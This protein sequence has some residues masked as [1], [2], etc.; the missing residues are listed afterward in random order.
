MKPISTLV[1]SVVCLYVL[2]AKFCPKSS[3]YEILFSPKKSFDQ[4]E[5]SIVLASSVSVAYFNLASTV[6]SPQGACP[7]SPE[8]CPLSSIDNRLVYLFDETA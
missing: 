8:I 1:S 2:T 7:E 4:V 3:A 6:T 5:Y